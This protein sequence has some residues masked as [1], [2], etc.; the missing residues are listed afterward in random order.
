MEER[1]LERTIENLKASENL[2]NDYIKMYR[3]ELP[4]LE[5]LLTRYKE[6]EALNKG[7]E[8]EI[9]RL[10]YCYEKVLDD[11]TKK[12]KNSIPKSKIKEKIEELKESIKKAKPDDLMYIEYCEDRIE[13]LQELLAEE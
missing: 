7:H 1:I 9:G 5:N 8:E 10:E 6:M 3:Y 4:E 11:L 13:V 12:L 2:G